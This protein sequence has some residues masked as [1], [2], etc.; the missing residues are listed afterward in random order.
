VETTAE[1]AVETTADTTAATN[2]VAPWLQEFSTQVL[3]D[4]GAFIAQILVFVLVS[5]VLFAIMLYVI[6]RWARGYEDSIDHR[7]LWDEERRAN[8][9]ARIRLLERYLRNTAIAA[10]IVMFI[11]LFAKTYRVPFLSELVLV[12]NTWLLTGGL[13]SI[14]YIII[15]IIAASFAL[16][17]VRNTA[18]ALV[19]ASGKSLERQI[20]RATT[21]RVVIESTAQIAI[22]T[23]VVLFALSSLG[24]PVASLLA[25]VGVLGLAISF[26]AQSLVKDVISGFFVLMEDQYGVGDVVQIAGLSGMVES[27]NLRITTLRDIE[28]RVHIIPNGQIDKATIMTKEWSRFVLDL[29]VAYR[30]DLDQALEILQDE[31]M[32]F[33]NDR[34]WAWRFVEAPEVL[35]VERF[36]ESGIALRVTFKTLP[37]EQ[38][39]VGREFRR[40]IK[41]R[42]DNEGIEI[43]FP[44]VT[45]YWGEGQSP[46]VLANTRTQSHVEE[47]R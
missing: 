44:H 19:P 40:R 30:T 18:R 14:G 27:V 7:E 25:G 20:A 26:G 12:A 29:D 32:L 6:K 28:G 31:S 47:V 42:F 38:W 22:G 45:F 37:R 4:P 35:G 23:M 43:P 11:A 36:A 33:F 46:P 15:M 1:T 5:L 21:I 9:H 34:A 13:A 10:G 16:R 3:A 24:A 2:L 39:A 17:L 8:E 41:R